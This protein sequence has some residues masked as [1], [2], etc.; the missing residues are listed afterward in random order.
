MVLLSVLNHLVSLHPLW[1]IMVYTKSLLVQCY[2]FVNIAIVW[3][4]E[5]QVFES[6]P[7]LPKNMANILNASDVA[8]Y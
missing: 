7:R 8:H 3:A 5:P 4:L 2:T 6:K 1:H